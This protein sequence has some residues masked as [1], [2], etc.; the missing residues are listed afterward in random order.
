MQRGEIA[1]GMSQDA[2][3]LAW[4]SPAAAWEGYHKGANSLRWD[5]FAS[6]PV[7]TNHYYGA[8]GFGGYGYGGYGHHG[9]YGY[10]GYGLGFGP[11]VAYIPY[12]KSTVW[13]VNNR[14]DSWERLR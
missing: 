11:E 7:V 5:Y 1:K 2:V 10:T 13:F 8:Y 3:V 6:Q 9:R 12:R 4:G 14:V